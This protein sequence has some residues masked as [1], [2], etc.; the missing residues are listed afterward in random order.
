MTLFNLLKKVLKDYIVMGY[1]HIR[2]NSKIIDYKIG[3]LL[4]E[5]KEDYSL[6]KLFEGINSAV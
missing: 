1:F 2:F 4:I 6:K 5:Y 3:K